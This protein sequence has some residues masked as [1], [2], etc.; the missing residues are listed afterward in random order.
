M[1]NIGKLD[2]VGMML[3]KE[4]SVEFIYFHLHLNIKSGGF[5]RNIQT[6]DAAREQ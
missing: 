1:S 3:S 2:C 6:G 5:R 4:S